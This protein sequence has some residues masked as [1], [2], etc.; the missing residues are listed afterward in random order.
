MARWKLDALR[1]F[2]PAQEA[3]TVAASAR[4]LA[5]LAGEGVPVETV[6]GGPLAW[7]RAAL[8]ARVIGMR[9]PVPWP[10]AVVR[11]LDP[12]DP[13][14]WPTP[15]WLP[16]TSGREQTVL[17]WPGQARTAWVDPWAWCGVGEL[18]AVVVW[19]DHA[20]G[21][22]PPTPGEVAAEVSQ[23]RTDG[24]LV[25]TITWPSL[26]VHIEHRPILVEAG[27]A[28][29]LRVRV[30]AR[31]GPVALRLGFAIRPA[32]D[33]GVRPI[34]D[35][36]RGGDGLWTADGE[37]V[38]AVE[39]AGDRRCWGS[40][41]EGDPWEAF[42]AGAAGSGLDHLHCAA[43]LAMGVEA[44]SLRLEP[45]SARIF[46]AIVGPGP[47]APAI[48]A[49]AQISSL[50]RGA[51]AHREGAL[52]AGSVFS[53]GAAAD[54][55]IVA[56][57]DRLLIEPVRGDLA[58]VLGAVALGRLGFVR[59]AG[60][61][62]AAWM[63]RVRRDG[64]YPGD[65][66]EEGAAL[67]WAA[68]TFVAWTGETSWI[69]EVRRSWG[70]LVDRLAA[71]PPAP[72]GQRWFGAEGSLRWTAL[73]RCA[74]LLMSAR[75]L[76]AIEPRAPAWALE[77]GKAREG[78]DAVLGPAPWT[79]SPGVA[80]DGSAAATLMLVWLG[81]LD[82]KHPGVTATRLAVE[83]GGSF[84]G[85]VLFAGG[86]H[87]GL[88]AT[89]FTAAGRAGALAD[90]FGALM[91]LAGPTG[92]FATVRHPARGA[93]GAGD[94]PLSAAMV[95]LVALDVVRVSRG[96]LVIGPQLQRAVD[97]PTPFGRIDGERGEDGVFY[98]RGR[99]RGGVAPRLGP[100]VAL[101]A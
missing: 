94:D 62:L 51:E 39:R 81:L 78:L 57:R 55:Q 84:G 98:L 32:S 22:W 47:S 63:G 64:S 1:L 16:V 38:L 19:L 52:R 45:D 54:E 10:R 82:A 35:L 42:R 83:S 66:G 33:D 5:A 43:G 68:A 25:T 26:R 50:F 27:M 100:M 86:A 79:L 96:T 46:G 56:A 70:R 9:P 31:Q 44:W 60:E 90:P 73:W 101:R 12:A 88:S 13:A 53:L 97:L 67:A 2:A 58:A 65:D 23:A 85:G 3:V 17:G 91:R 89:A 30:I 75:S 87:I 80:A 14:F 41:S 61:R 95:A 4:A 99:F 71:E 48:L 7:T 72:G 34:F 77:G 76:R 6:L 29:G 49:R 40:R 93:L 36:R 74:A 18:P 69:E 92:A 15:G 28:L 37:A 21:H 24:G 8:T 59:R 11:A 20:E